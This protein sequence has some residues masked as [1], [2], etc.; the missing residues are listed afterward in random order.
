MRKKIF[1]GAMFCAFTLALMIAA[2]FYLEH[3]V[4]AAAGDPCE[5]ECWDDAWANCDYGCRNYGGCLGAQWWFSKCDYS[6]TYCNNR[7][8][9]LCEGGTPH[10]HLDFVCSE[11]CSSCDK[12]FW[13]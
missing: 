12:S 11:P 2:N 1:Y 3:N 7:Y 6:A 8:D 5:C 9:L 4:Y 10:K 13:E